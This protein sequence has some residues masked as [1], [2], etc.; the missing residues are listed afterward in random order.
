VSP[1]EDRKSKAERLLIATA[2]TIR[3]TEDGIEA[4]VVG[5]HDQYRLQLGPSGWVCP[6]PARLRDCS[7]VRAVEAVTGWTR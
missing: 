7:H 1:R 3:C 4:L 2:V 5:D 6:C